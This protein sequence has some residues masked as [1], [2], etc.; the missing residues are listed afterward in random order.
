MK[1]LGG[2]A[3]AAGLLLVSSAQAA[4][5][6]ERHSIDAG[7]AGGSSSSFSFGSD[8]S[9]DGGLPANIQISESLGSHGHGFAH[10][11]TAKSWTAFF[12]KYGDKVSTLASSKKWS[13]LGQFIYSIT[14]QRDFP[15]HCE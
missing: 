9:S 6:H 1:V 2:K 7:H 15:V 5:V 13:E 8:S 12:S 3:V 11:G 4:H 14:P 10:E